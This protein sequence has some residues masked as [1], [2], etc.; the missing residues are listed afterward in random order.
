MVASSAIVNGKHIHDD[1]AYV[2][3]NG[4]RYNLKMNDAHNGFSE[5]PAAPSFLADGTGLMPAGSESLPSGAWVLYYKTDIQIGPSNPPTTYHITL[6]D[7]GGVTSDEAVKTIVASSSTYIVTFSVEDGQGGS[8]KAKPEGG[9]GSTTTATETVSVEHGTQVTFTATPAEGWEV[10]SW[11]N[12][13]S[14]DSSNNKKATL[15]SVIGNTTVTVK[16]KKKKT[17]NSSDYNAWTLLKKVVE[18]A[19][20]NST[21]TIDGK[22]E[23]S[24]GNSGQIKIDK[25]LTIRGKTVD[26]N[27]LDANGLSRIFKVENGATL[28]LKNLTLKGGKADEAED[29]DKCG[30]AI[31]ASNAIVNI[32]DCTITGNKATTNGGGIY[33]D[34]GTTDITNCTF[35]GNTANNGGGIYMTDS[36][37]PTVTISGGTIGGTGPNEANKATGTDGKGGGIYVGYLC[38]LRLNSALL[39]TS[40]KA[41]K[42]GGVYAN[43]ADVSMQGGTR[44]AVDA[45]NNDVYLDNTSKI[46]VFS[47]L[48]AED[49]V[50]RITVLNDEYKPTTQVLKAGT[51]VNLA[52]EAGKF[53][54]TPKGSEPWIVGNSGTLLNFGAI[55]LNEIKVRDSSMSPYLITNRENLVNKLLFYKTSAG[56]Y[57]VMVITEVN[58]TS[59]GGRGHIKFNYKT[60]NADGSVKNNRDNCELEGLFSFDL[61]AETGSAYDFFLNNSSTQNLAPKNGAEF[62][63]LP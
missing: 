62:Y 33:V 17:V 51:G 56:N 41:A 40:N 2:T 8:L 31:Y 54:V 23:A 57:G 46:K 25:T 45:V 18:I 1:I 42:G 26:G 28:F 29:A 60:F 22:I 15:S 13:V 32:T 55:S 44:I 7:K 58:A 61:D 37:Y 34:G 4:T 21:I 38:D 6:I 10:D 16:F 3:V 63:V 53:A 49:S 12:N 14:V 36:S 52:S 9:T 19:D 27:I 43:Y 24:S 50:A 47:T 59:Y 5:K 20:P 35:T 39:I 11:S 48:T 30:G